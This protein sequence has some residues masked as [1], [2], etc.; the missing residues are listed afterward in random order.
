[1]R[2]ILYVYNVKHTHALYLYNFLS[3][4]LLFTLHNDVT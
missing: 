2:F 1:M 4:S 3:F